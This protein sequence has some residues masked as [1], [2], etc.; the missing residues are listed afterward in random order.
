MDERY[1]DDR[2]SG[3]ADQRDRGGAKTV[4]SP[5][6]VAVLSEFFQYFR[7]DKKDVYKRQPS[8]C[9]QE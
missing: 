8:V 9:T 7:H 4:E 1:L 6:H 5:L 3:R 2:Q